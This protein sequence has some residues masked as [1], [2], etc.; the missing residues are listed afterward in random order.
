MCCCDRTFIGTGDLSSLEQAAEAVSVS[1]GPDKGPGVRNTYDIK[2]STE[3]SSGRPLSDLR[4]FSRFGACPFCGAAMA[5]S[6]LQP[7]RGVC[8]G[9]WA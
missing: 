7:G 2:D 3:A 4:N 8:V 1:Y 9:V 6:L 5:A